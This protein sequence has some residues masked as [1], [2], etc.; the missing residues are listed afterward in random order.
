MSAMYMRWEQLHFPSNGDKPD[1]TMGEWKI[2]MP[3]ILDTPADLYQK[4]TWASPEL[5]WYR[6]WLPMASQLKGEG[7]RK[8]PVKGLVMTHHSHLVSPL[9]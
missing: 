4:P 8:V 9:I 5:L 3:S 2:S 6:A 7:L 1:G